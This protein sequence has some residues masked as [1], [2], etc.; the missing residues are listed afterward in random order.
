[1]PVSSTGSPATGS[2][3]GPTFSPASDPK[4]SSSNC[5]PRGGQQQPHILMVVVDDAGFND[6]GMSMNNQFSTP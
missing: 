3:P 6:F 5:E 1:M 4:Y 2:T